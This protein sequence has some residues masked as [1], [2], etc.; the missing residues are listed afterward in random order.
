MRT[1]G[2]SA[3][4]LLLISACSGSQD[5]RDAGPSIPLHLL[6][7]VLAHAAAEEMR[8]PDLQCENGERDPDWAALAAELRAHDYARRGGPPVDGQAMTDA[9]ITARLRAEIDVRG[10]PDPCRLGDRAAKQLWFVV[11]HSPDEALL[12]DGL[13]YFETAAAYGF[14]P[15]SQVAT[16]HDRVL[17][18]AGEPQIYGTQYLCDPHTGRRE[19]WRTAD[20]E[21]LDARRRQAGLIPADWEERIL[22]HR[23]ASCHR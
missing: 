18:R 12:R 11:Q 13:A 15:R 2:L 14:V 19:R 6:P 23:G 21:G 22:N 16:M 8:T 3:L 17:M 5:G 20:P 10:W 9:E 4:I 1:L 7:G